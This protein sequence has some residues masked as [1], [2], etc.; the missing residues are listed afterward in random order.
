MDEL[1][2]SDVLITDYSS[3][4]FDFTFLNKPVILY[5]PDLESYMKNRSFYC[6]IEEMKNYAI[7]TSKELVDTIILNDYKINPFFKERLPENKKKNDK[8]NNPKRN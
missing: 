2:K 1:V 7:K 4:G 5:Q 6:S 8:Q 3:V